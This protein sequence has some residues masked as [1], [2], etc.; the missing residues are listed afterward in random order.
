MSRHFRRLSL[1]QGSSLCTVGVLVGLALLV[2]VP[3]IRSIPVDA[4]FLLVAWFCLWFFSHDLVHHVVGRIVGVGFRYYFLGRSSI[5]KLSLP[6]VSNLLRIVPVLGLKIDRSS[7]KSVSP[8]GARSMYASGAVISMFLPWIV[9]PT[10]FSVGLPVG[11]LLTILTIANV[12]FTL[13]FSPQVGDL[14]H[15]RM[16]RS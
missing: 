13:Y 4:L 11:I 9:I 1:A 5:T 12:V 2:V 10:G 16:V 3:H 7:L 6:V 15:A 8:N 14:H